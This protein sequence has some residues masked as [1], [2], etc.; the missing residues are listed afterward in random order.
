MRISDWSSDVCS[1]DRASVA[2]PLL[3]ESGAL[4]DQDLV[5]L[6]V[7]ED[8][9]KQLAVAGRPTLSEAVADA[10]V[11]HGSEEVVVAVVSNPGATLGEPTLDLA[12]D[13]FPDSERVN[14]IG[15]ASCR[16]RVGPYV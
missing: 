13:R 3:S 12:L 15:R 9:A 11:A 14:E 8:R 6:V 4:T 1:S 2:T 5:D 7:G 16:E 10:L